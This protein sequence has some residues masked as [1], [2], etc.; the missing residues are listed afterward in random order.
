MSEM[1]LLKR[2]LDDSALRAESK[3]VKYEKW[4]DFQIQLE[5]CL[6]K[7]CLCEVSLGDLLLH[8][9]RFIRL[10]GGGV[11]SGKHKIGGLFCGYLKGL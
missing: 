5:T 10:Q 3:K 8:L 7:K 6:E 9:G 1:N 11:H 4:T 2:P